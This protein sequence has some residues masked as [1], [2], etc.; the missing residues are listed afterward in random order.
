MTPALESPFA[1]RRVLVVG[2]DDRAAAL[3]RS[4]A[5]DGIETVRA[6]SAPEALATLD[7]VE[8]TLLVVVDGIESRP[9][10]VFGAAARRGHQLPGVFVGSKARQLPPGVEQAPAGA[11]AAASVIRQRLLVASAP[12]AEPAVDNDPLAA[13]GDTV[14]HELRNHLSAARLAVDS[15]EGPTIEQARDALDRLEGLAREAEV[16]AA[17]EVSD[18]ESVSLASAAT[19]A[20]DRV[21][22]PDASIRVDV[23]GTVQADPALLTLL[24]ENLVRNAV[25]HGGDDV[26]VRVTDTDA[27]F[28]VTD[29]GP[30]FGDGDPFAWG[31]SGDGGQG[32]GLGIVRRIAEA[33]DWEIV[34]ENDGG[35]RVEIGT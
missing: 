28:A 32:A 10:D 24:L 16:I 4:L 11:D 14:S 23:E 5:A 31:Y 3:E 1:R 21:R 13:F 6:A 12:D 15:L 27:G 2:N 19:G 7:A 18:T 8:V 34:A 22:A 9:A 30:G 33:H 20:A 26:T 29:D 35:A 25:E 17:G